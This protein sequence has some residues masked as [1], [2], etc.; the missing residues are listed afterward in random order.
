MGAPAPP[1]PTTSLAEILNDEEPK[2]LLIL[3]ESKVNQ[4][5]SH[6]VSATSGCSLEQLE[7]VNAALMDCI[8]KPRA[9]YHREVVLLH[10]IEELTYRECA[11]VLEVPEG[12]VK[13]RLFHAFRRLRGSLSGYVQSDV[14]PEAAP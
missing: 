2:P 6:L 4:L 5:H 13:S 1:R 3:D 8:W 9:D 10:E 11:A 12:T 14:L 7:H